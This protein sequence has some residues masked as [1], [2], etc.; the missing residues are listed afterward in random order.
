[1][2][3]A[4]FLDFLEHELRLQ[5]VAFSRADLLAFVAGAWPWIEEDPDDMTFWA[6]EFIASGRASL[7][8]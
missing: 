3:Q 2:S 4:D 6:R 7:T 5:G 8:T 1:M